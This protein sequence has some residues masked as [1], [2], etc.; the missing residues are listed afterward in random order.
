MN[1]LVRWGLGG[2]QKRKIKSEKEA[3][4][5]GAKGTQKSGKQDPII[6]SFSHQI[7]G[8]RIVKSSLSS[9]S[10]PLFSFYS[11]E[12]VHARHT[13]LSHPYSPH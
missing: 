10:A 8:E 3:L 4:F 11:S 6:D 5:V 13:L 1:T 2:E 12:V 7:N 9:C